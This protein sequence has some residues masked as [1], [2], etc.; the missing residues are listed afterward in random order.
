MI[1]VL[2]IQ[3]CTIPPL[4]TGNEI[5]SSP[6]GA[7]TNDVELG[8]PLTYRSIENTGDIVF[9]FNLLNESFPPPPHIRL[10]NAKKKKK[11]KILMK[12]F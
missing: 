7:G 8:F 1:I 3:L 9:T 6:R 4:F 2:V 10:N 5:F 11:K 12:V